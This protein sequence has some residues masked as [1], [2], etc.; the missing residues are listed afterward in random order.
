MDQ[1]LCLEM[2]G[3]TKRFPG[4][5]A[6][7]RVDLD[8]R[9]GEILALLGEN[10][11][12]KSTLLKILAGAYQKDEGSIRIDGKQYEFATPKEA[13]EA[14]VTVI[15]Q[16]LN[17]LPELTVAENIF[18]G[19]Q[20]TKGPLGRIDWDKMNREASKILAFMGISVNPKTL[21]SNLSMAEKQ[22]VE[23]A[24][25]LSKNMKILVMDEPT[26]ALNEA[27]VN[28]LFEIVRGMKEKGISI[29]YISHRLEELFEISDRVMIM[30]DGRRIDV[31]D[32]TATTKD[33]LVTMM[34][35]RQINEMFPKKYLEPGETLLE[36]RHLT[37]RTKVKG[38]SL[39]L[40]KKEILGIF[41]LMGAGRTS[42]ADTLFGAEPLTGGEILIEGKK[43]NLRNAKDA[44]KAGIALVPSERKMAGL[45][46]GMSVKE[47]ITVATIS[48][49]GKGLSINLRAETDKAQR[50][51]KDL[52]IKTPSIH[53]VAESLSG[54]NQQKV[55]LAKWLEAK[56]KLLILNEPT[57]GI[58]VGA[59]VEIYNLME[60]FCEQG[61]G[62]LMISSELP[63]IL[64]LA[65][66]IL[67]MSE[68]RI[69]GE[70]TGEEA[71]QEKL[72]KCAVG[73]I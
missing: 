33:E 3:I 50:W 59:K 66:R 49:L 40:K 34:V 39:T 72:M 41:G 2:K 9:R 73:G 55:V 24:K 36:V 14:G 54:G 69:A 13:S 4:V 45:I 27:E 52:N 11:A 44:I 70:F 26:A 12:G 43:L 25:A 38:V 29:I 37:N 63:E 67:V 18:L 8:L 21:M 1:E 20:P 10:G 57:R 16:E 60:T 22:L 23:I 48:E 51:V 28:K 5:L 32:T 62:I 71:T 47:N 42:L 35:G 53:T 30:R 7:D 65:D 64:A 58:D 6:L 31:V 19:R 56:P 46:L 15:Y 68:G 61:L 17:Y